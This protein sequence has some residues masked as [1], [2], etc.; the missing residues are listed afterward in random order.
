RE[1]QAATKR[2]PSPAAA[3]AQNPK[4]LQRGHNSQV[5]E[6]NPRVN[7]DNAPRRGRGEENPRQD[8]SRRGRDS[9]L[10]K[11]ADD[12]SNPPPLGLPMRH[13]PFDEYLAQARAEVS[14]GRRSSAND[15]M[16]RAADTA[17]RAKLAGL[18]AVLE[19]TLRD[20]NTCNWMLD[21]TR[22]ELQRVAASGS[23]N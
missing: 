13:F 10:D 16:L 17:V 9:S 1:D 14:A 4:R 21:R 5:E 3:P 19:C 2:A 22:L 11:K 23:G 6:D 15:E 18:R 7:E 8:N 20:I 12:K